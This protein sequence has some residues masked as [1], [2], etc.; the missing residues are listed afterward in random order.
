MAKKTATKIS[1]PSRTAKSAPKPR[2]TS[3]IRT[4]T[5]TE[6]AVRML[7]GRD[8]ASLAELMEALGWL[9]HSVRALLSARIG[10]GLKLPLVKTRRPG[11][12]T[13]YHIGALRPGKE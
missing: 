13:R 10:K 12:E 3:N 5:K 9:Q 1:R 4:E 11:E 2:N 6:I 8:G 7:R